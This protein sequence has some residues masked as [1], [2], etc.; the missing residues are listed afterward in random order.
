MDAASLAR[1]FALGGAARLSDGPVARGK[2]GVVWRLETADGSWAAKVPLRRSDEDEVRAATEF[3]EAAHAA[4][5]PTPRVR[6]TAEGHVFADV[7]GS[8]VR[9]YEWVDLLAL[10]PA[11]RPGAGG[12]GRGRHAP[13]RR[14]VPR[15]VGPVVSRPGRCRIGGTSWS[16]SSVRAGAPFADRLADLRDELVAL[17]SWL[18]PPETLRTCHRDLWADNILPTADGG[19]CVVDWDESGPAD[20]S[21]ELGLRALRVRPR[22]PRPRPRPHRRLPGRRWPG[23]SGSARALLD[24][25]R[26]AGPHH[27]DRRDRLADAQPALT[28]PC[29]TLPP[30]SARSSTSRTPATLLD[31]LL[32]TV[33]TTIP[34]HAGVE[35]RRGRCE[36]VPMVPAYEQT[37][38]QDVIARLRRHRR[39]ASVRRRSGGVQPDVPHGDRGGRRRAR[40]WSR[41]FRD[42]VFME[43]LDVTFA[44]L[45]LEAY[46]ATPARCRRHGLHCSRAG[47]TLAVAD[48]VRPGR[49]ELPH[50]ARPSR[51]RHLDLPP[52][53]RLT[54]RRRASARTTRRSTTCSPRASPRSGARSSPRPARQLDEQ[55]GPVAHLIN[56][57]KIDKARDAAWVNVEALWAIRRIGSLADRYRAALA[58][59]VGMAS[60]CLLT[61]CA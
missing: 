13:G 57:W 42:P 49:D 27:R 61:P 46:D 23:D 7:G 48:P 21:Q 37:S 47:T 2:Q 29:A 55:V 58:R 39:R 43:H 16:S 9:L 12:C 40:R 20:P 50:R 28:G 35:P 51:R 36:A 30:G 18:E 3:Q 24:A 54:R 1:R 59:T 10:R 4:G 34:A 26:A 44:S 45:W 19:V 17:E 5:V 38:V 6:R 32:K 41:V 56:S 15:D 33:S 14:S 31:T 25:H 52:A 60:R 22:R 11:S 53:R 8:Q